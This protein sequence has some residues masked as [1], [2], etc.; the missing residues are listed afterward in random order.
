MN[1]EQSYYG[2]PT[3][4]VEVSEQDTIIGKSCGTQGHDIVSWENSVTMR[5][6]ADRY[7]ADR[8]FTAEYS[9]ISYDVAEPEESMSTAVVVI[10]LYIIAYIGTLHT[11]THI[12]TIACNHIHNIIVRIRIRMNKNNRSLLL[13]N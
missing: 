7:D 2:C 8:A 6:Y 1:I 13:R 4:G 12:Y 3:S 11:H 10:E 5:F 9:A